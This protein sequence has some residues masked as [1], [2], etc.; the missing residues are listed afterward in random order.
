MDTTPPD[1]NDRRPPPREPKPAAQQPAEPTL[2]ER[3]R[4]AE[5]RTHFTEH[6]V[7][8]LNHQLIEAYRLIERLN[9]RID[10]LEQRLAGVEHHAGSYFSTDP[11]ERP[12]HAAPPPDRDA[13]PPP[14]PP[15]PGSTSA[16]N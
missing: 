15:P 2:A 13:P 6:T 10:R 3:L 4:D 9:H 1:R 8:Q 14:P 11:N 5:D 7:D 16:R 12:P